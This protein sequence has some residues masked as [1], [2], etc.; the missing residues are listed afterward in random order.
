[1]TELVGTIVTPDLSYS[2][3][4]RF[5]TRI[6]GVEA[7]AG[8]QRRLIL[9]GFVDL[10]VHG[11]GGADFMD[12]EEAVR[13]AARFHAGHGTAALLATTVTA[14]IEDLEA[15]LTG[16]NTVIQSP[17]LGEARVLGVHLEG[18]FISPHKLGAQPPFA[19]PPDLG[20]M[21][22]FLRLAPIKVVTLAPEL[23]GAIELIRFLVEQNVQV[24][25][26]HSAATYDQAKAGFE[27]GAQGFTHFFNAMTG[28]HHREP[29]VVGL[30]LEKAEWAEVVPD[31]LHVHPATV[32]ALWKAVPRL[33]AVTDA[34]EAAGMPE[35]EY[36]LGRNHVFKRGNGIFLES[37]SLAGSALTL[38]Q[39]V[40]NLTSWG[41]NL[42]DAVEMTSARPSAYLGL[43]V[44]N[45]LRV[46]ARADIVVLSED[47]RV[48]Q[49]YIGGESVRSLN[50]K[51]SYSEP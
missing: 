21:E 32:R 37:G 2:G 34:V 22:H 29:G 33:Y 30:G 20:L 39:A 26:G 9:P 19:T 46:G 12:G 28:L 43:E 48:E 49:V 36:R 35:G 17:G 10:H 6:E 7:I 38:D 1:M 16:I 5:D 31:G 4:L 23:P 11:G 42:G 45:G 15:A 44:P 18:P 41:L 25:I 3:R 50:P 8:A 24:Q 47:L 13:R 51:Q 27:A 14:P 40:R